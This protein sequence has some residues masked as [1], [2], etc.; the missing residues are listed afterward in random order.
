MIPKQLELFQL[1]IHTNDIQAIEKINNRLVRV[2][3]EGGIVRH[4]EVIKLSSRRIALKLLE[5]YTKDE[6]KKDDV[7][8]RL[9]NIIMYHQYPKLRNYEIEDAL[10]ELT[11]RFYG[12]NELCLFNGFSWFTGD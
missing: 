3:Y 4:H 11:G 1:P 12:I 8:Y 7:F 2:T 5:T 10:H 9:H 6:L